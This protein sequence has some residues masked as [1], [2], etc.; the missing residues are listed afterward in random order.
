MHIGSHF[1]KLLQAWL[2]RGQVEKARKP[3]EVHIEHVLGGN[4][5][6]YC[7]TPNNTLCMESCS[8]L[9]CGTGTS[10]AMECCGVCCRSSETPSNL[11][12]AYL[13]T[14]QP[15]K[16]GVQRKLLHSAAQV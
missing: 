9:G 13:G 2:L 11:S 8:E 12:I 10:M 14:Q 7:L 16:E 4:L 5:V 1:R 3:L 15:H 6:C